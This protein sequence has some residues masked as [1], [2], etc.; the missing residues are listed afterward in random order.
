MRAMRRR[1]PSSARAT[2][3]VA[4]AILL[5]WAL[6]GGLLGAPSA[7]ATGALAPGA[8]AAVLSAAEST[9]R[10]CRDLPETT[11]ELTSTNAT[12]ELPRFDPALGTLLSVEV[13]ANAT[14]HQ[15]TTL[16]NM[17]T[18]PARFSFVSTVDVQVVVPTVTLGPSTVD[19]VT[20]NG[21]VVLAGG[22]ALLLGP[23]HAPVD[24]GTT[25]VAGALDDYI[26]A[27]QTVQAWFETFTNTAMVGGGGNIFNPMTTTAE[28]SVCITYTYTI[29]APAPTVRVTKTAAPSTVPETGGEVDYTITVTNPDSEPVT[30]ASLIDSAGPISGSATCRVGTVLPAGQSCT[31]TDRRTVPPGAPG[32]T[33]VNTVTVTGSRGNAT[34]A[35]ASSSAPVTYTD[36]PPQVA[37]TKTVSP[38]SVPATGGQVTYTVTV[39]NPGT[40]EVTLASL[41]DSALSEFPA[42]C[43]A[44]TVLPPA[45]SCTVVYPV[46]LPAGTPGE[47]QRNTVNVVASD[48][49][50]LTPTRS[51]TATVTYAALPPTP[52]PSPSTTVPLPETGADAAPI[53]ALGGGLTAIGAFLVLLGR[54]RRV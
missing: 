53:A 21:Q 5:G 45:G 29:E 1:L 22:A 46:T 7:A 25:T 10:V 44:G 12:L 17:S 52:S 43:R 15:A 8:T 31:F 3:P 9:A 18:G 32:S 51:A 4:T 19:G 41:T 36:V 14:V 6:T 38:S 40:V 35:P 11:T 2:G 16:T 37:V 54:R 33:T 39:T 13:S 48:G 42:T 27:G 20:T 30:I 34:S 23:I 47:S 50:S 26:G 28:G 49:T 24:I